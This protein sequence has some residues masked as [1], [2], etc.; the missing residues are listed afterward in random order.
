[1]RHEVLPLLADVMGRDPVPLLVR[2]A[3]LAG[4]ERELLDALACEIDPTDASELDAAPVALAR[5]AVRR[6]LRDE[7]PPDAASVERVL[8]VA[9]GEAIGCEVVG[10]RRVIRRSGRLV[11]ETPANPEGS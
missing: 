5:R 8:A 2:A 11:L 7:H 6:W 1:V 10:G 3:E 4:D 9:R